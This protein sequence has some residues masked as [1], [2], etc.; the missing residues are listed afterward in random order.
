MDLIFPNNLLCIPKF[1]LL[2]VFIVKY[3]FLFFNDNI[4]EPREEEVKEAIEIVSD[5]LSDDL[6]MMLLKHFGYDSL[7]TIIE[8]KS[9]TEKRKAD[10]E[11]ELEVC[12][13]N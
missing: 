11:Q 5:Y 8:T 6:T 2:Q 7:N 9:T 13:I 12:F 10:W 1:H 3:N 4:I